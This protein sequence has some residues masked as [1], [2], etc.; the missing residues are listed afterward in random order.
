MLL[1]PI[2]EVFAQAKRQPKS[3][4]YSLGQIIPAFFP[5]G[6]IINWD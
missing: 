1:R 6:H 3:G 5:A 2:P 4:G